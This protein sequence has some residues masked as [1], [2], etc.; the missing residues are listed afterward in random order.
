MAKHP[1]S[2]YGLALFLF[3]VMGVNAAPVSFTPLTKTTAVVPTNSAVTVEYTV[4]NLT[5]PAFIF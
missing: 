1:F 5:T 2:L 4:K 3:M